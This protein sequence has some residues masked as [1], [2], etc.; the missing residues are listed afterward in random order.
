MVKKHHCGLVNF[1]NCFF[2]FSELC[3]F[4]LVDKKIS[5]DKYNLTPYKNFPKV[6]HTGV[7]VGVCCQKASQCAAGRLRHTFAIHNND[8][9]PHVKSI[10]RTRITFVAPRELSR[11]FFLG[12]KNWLESAGPAHFK[13]GLNYSI[14][15]REI[16]G[17][18]QRA[19]TKLSTSRLAWMKRKSLHTLSLSIMQ[20]KFQTLCRAAFGFSSKAVMH[21]TVGLAVWSLHLY[22]YWPTCIKLTLLYIVQKLPIFICMISLFSNK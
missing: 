17:R 22:I 6:R 7:A 21:G 20:L 5:S 10:T 19:F 8:L 14:G 11:S 1:K 18:E 12:Y 3:F 15:S 13:E 4:I 2:S 9:W 16:A